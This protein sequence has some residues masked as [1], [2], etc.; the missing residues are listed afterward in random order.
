MSSVI[1]LAE[2]AAKACC[3]GERNNRRRE[4]PSSCWVCGCQQHRKEE[5][6]RS[7]QMKER[8]RVEEKEGAT[9]RKTKP[10]LH[11]WS[12]GLAGG[13]PHLG[14]AVPFTVPWAPSAWGARS[15]SQFWYLL[16]KSFGGIPW[17]ADRRRRKQQQ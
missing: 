13:N 16:R 15:D 6:G 11:I 7:W 2:V 3:R 8:M 4:G 1:P 14:S 12:Q 9:A 17:L 5:R 10:W